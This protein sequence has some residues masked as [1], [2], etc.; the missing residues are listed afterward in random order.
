MFLTRTLPI[1][2]DLDVSTIMNRLSSLHPPEVHTNNTIFRTSKQNLQVGRVEDQD[3]F[4][5]RVEDIEPILRYCRYNLDSSSGTAHAAAAAEEH[6][7]EMSR[8]GA[9]GA[10]GD[11]LAAKLES[12]VAEARK[13]QASALDSVQWRGEK[14]AVRFEAL[15]V[16][17]VKADELARA[18]GPT[19]SAR[20]R[21]AGEGG[22]SGGEGEGEDPKP[23]QYLKVCAVRMET[24]AQS[25]TPYFRAHAL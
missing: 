15:R 4:T 14:V 6:L 19:S 5:R 13:K 9:A 24:Q 23:G 25:V 10:G 11:L 16:A 21:S 7:I 3:L 2:N 17:L 12:V 1:F 22:E 18:L 8:K 20:S